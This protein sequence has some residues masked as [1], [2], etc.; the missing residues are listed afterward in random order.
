VKLDALARA[1]GRCKV[2]TKAREIAIS[3]VIHDLFE[4]RCAIA[5]KRILFENL[6]L[7]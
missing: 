1:H 4:L 7:L 5:P 6:G 3:R 2:L